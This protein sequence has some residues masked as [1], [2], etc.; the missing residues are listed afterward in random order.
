MADKIL[1]FGKYGSSLRVEDYHDLLIKV[2]EIIPSLKLNKLERPKEHRESYVILYYLLH[3]GSALRI[4]FPFTL[5]HRDRPDF[6][7][8]F[9]DSSKIGFE[10]SEA[11]SVDYQLWLTE[12]ERKRRAHKIA[13]TGV[14]AIEA[15]S[16]NAGFVGTGAG[17]HFREAETRW[18][19]TV[20]LRLAKKIEDAQ[21]YHFEYRLVL[22]LYS[23]TGDDVEN[24]L[25]AAKKLRNYINDVMPY[26][27]VSILVGSSYLLGDVFGE[28]FEH[29]AYMEFDEVENAVESLERVALFL[30]EKFPFTKWKWVWFALF[31]ALY[32]FM[33]NALQGTTPDNVLQPIQCT[34]DECGARFSPGI[35]SDN[36]YRCPNCG[37]DLGHAYV[38]RLISFDEALRRVQT[39]EWMKQYTFSE[40]LLL[41]KEDRDKI[42]KMK[43][44]SEGLFEF[45]PKSWLIHL[46]G[47]KGIVSC[48]VDVI[49]RL[50]K[51]EHNS[52]LSEDQGR[53]KTEYIQRIRWL[54][55]SPAALDFGG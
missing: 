2:R 19:E 24:Y 32:G 30:E 29:D 9:E 7:I 23:N 11:T 14:P 22:V 17:E 52:F 18:V 16:I 50:V 28:S 35:L 1:P 15:S 55:E 33:I 10:I 37:V 8:T 4:Q 54:L 46:G 49:D 45:V 5:V 47:A 20:R 41:S 43:A 40:P 3:Q 38:E 39:R 27:T 53:R 44:L 42:M 48:V 51:L 34:N 31:H 21:K 25:S 13:D 12:E 6:E 36:S 26:T